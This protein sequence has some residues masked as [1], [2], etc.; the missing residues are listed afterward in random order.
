M[1]TP[2]KNPNP[3][4]QDDSVSQLVF[5]FFAGRQINKNKT[6]KLQYCINTGKQ[7]IDIF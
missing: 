6:K 7:Q 3:S 4:V 5:E 2:P 1:N